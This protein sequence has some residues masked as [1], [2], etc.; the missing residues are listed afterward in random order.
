MNYTEEITIGRIIKDQR[1]SLGLTTRR[2]CSLCGIAP[3]SLREYENQGFRMEAKTA[4]SI[5]S[6]LGINVH[7]FADLIIREATKSFISENTSAFNSYVSQKRKDPNHKNCIF[8]CNRD[9]K[10]DLRYPETGKYLRGLREVKNKTI[11]DVGKETKRSRRV[12]STIELGKGSLSFDIIVTLSKYYNINKNELFRMYIIE[13]IS[14]YSKYYKSRVNDIAKERNTD[15]GN[16]PVDSNVSKIPKE[17]KRHRIKNSDYKQQS[18]VSPSFASFLSRLMGDN[19]SEFAR[20]VGMGHSG[21]S[22]LLKGK[23]LPTLQTILTI[24]DV[25]GEDPNLIFKEVLKDRIEWYQTKVVLV[26]DAFLKQPDSDVQLYCYFAPREHVI[27]HSDY[28]LKI[29]PALLKKLREKIPLTVTGLSNLIDCSPSHVD[30]AERG[31][32]PPDAKMLYHLARLNDIAPG[33]IL[34]T[35]LEEKIEHCVKVYRE[36]FYKMMNSQ[37]S[38][39]EVCVA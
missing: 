20:S 13:K 32:Q 33:E 26:F 12:I 8:F 17:E 31:E 19:I 16:M 28:K 39:E 5:A 27:S 34:N 24:C 11:K 6:V 21:I 22:R 14:S 10:V 3:T 36:K 29:S 2:F 23:S 1:T 35:C 7:S 9:K 30:E 15:V 25:Y 38:L 4:V 37:T 18:I